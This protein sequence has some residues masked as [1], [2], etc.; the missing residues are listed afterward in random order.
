M[1]EMIKQINS[2][3]EKMLSLW[4][5]QLI[6]E[7]LILNLSFLSRSRIGNGDR[8]QNLGKQG[9][10]EAVKLGMI[11]IAF[12]ATLS[13]LSESKGI[14]KLDH[15]YNYLYPSDL[16]HV[17]YLVPAQFPVTSPLPQYLNKSLKFPLPT[18]ILLTQNTAVT[19]QSGQLIYIGVIALIF[20]WAVLQGLAKLN[21]TATMVA[22]GNMAV[23]LSNTDSSLE[24][25]PDSN[26][27]QDAENYARLAIANQDGL[28]DWDLQTNTIYFS[29]RW[30][31][32]LG[33]TAAE[34]GNSL[35]EWLSR[36][37]PED[38]SRLQAEIGNH[39]NQITPY[40]EIEYRLLHKDGTYRWIMSRGQAFRDKNQQ[41]HHLA[42][43]NTDITKYKVA[44]EQLLHDAFHDCLTGL[45]NRALFM[46]RLKHAF[47][48]TKRR[49]N[50]LFA[51]LFLDLDRFKSINDK[52]GH[53]TGDQ[54][55]IE[56]VQRLIP[57]LRSGD[58]LARLG[59]D[60][61]AILL[62]DINYVS[63]TTL[64]ADRIQA[65]LQ[66]PFHINNHELLTSVS[67]GIVLSTGDYKK[68]EEI[69]RDADIAMY[70]A[71]SLGK[72]CYQVFDPSMNFQAV[73]VL[74]LK[75]DLQR[76]I[77][78]SEFQL[79]YQPIVSLATGAITGFEALIR[80]QHSHRGNV[81]PTEFIPF[82]EETGLIVPLGYWIMHEACR[83]MYRWQELF[84]FSSPL[85]INVNLSS[86]QFFQAD[87]IP[88]I[89]KILAETKLNPQSLKLEITESAI[90]ENIESAAQTIIQLKNLGIQLYI[91]DF[92][93]GYSSLSFIHRFPFDALKIDTSFIR[94]ID[95]TG[96]N[97]EIIKT[98]VALAQNLGIYIVAEGVETDVQLQKLR[99]MG[100][101]NGQ[102][103]GYFFSKP[104]NPED[105]QLLLTKE[106]QHQSN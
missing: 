77:N 71:K 86:K 2:K 37:H 30:K 49:Q 6:K 29:E 31:T 102:G 100:C 4:K 48:L 23:H 7:Q 106:F 94:K 97:L 84:P 58:T 27:V 22:A 60:E 44:E 34:I 51:V 21:R 9:L 92:G 80:W 83:Q 68:P 13:T 36:V 63:D 20:Y 45:S 105:V 72:A 12:T 93:T 11:I 66:S 79:E 5:R 98:I 32:M 41:I 35:V 57:C 59:G 10:S 43:A 81:S 74:Q 73:T 40:L 14:A 33:Y 26:S 1:K 28:W 82:A 61:F 69:L 38:L 39:F 17:P 70:R 101:I 96:E 46:D 95:T 87:L 91:D 54:L 103:Q 56:V 78:N 65:Q 18:P 75:N 89:I 47:Q 8:Q 19:P 55:L 16:S 99:E 62:E 24:I 90:M 50:Y 85:S 64:V 104:L 52:F 42:G 76:A 88:E 3:A 15:D 53:Q 67:I 25:H